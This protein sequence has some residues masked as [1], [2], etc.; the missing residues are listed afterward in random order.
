MK[1]DHHLKAFLRDT[2]NLNQT[3][4][5]T[6]KQRVETITDF[7]KQLED[8]KDLFI[9]AKPQGSWAHG[10]II[11]PVGNSEFDADIVVFLKE[12][13]DWEPKDYIDSLYRGFKNSK[14][15][16][17]MVGRN[18]RCVTLDYSGDFHLDVVPCIR[19]ENIWNE[20]TEWI[21]NRTE[22][23]EEQTNPN[24][25]SEWF[26]EK[27][28]ITDGYL[29]K[30]VRL[31]K[32]LRDHKKTFSA[33]SILLTT[34]LAE[35]VNALDGLGSGFCD[36]ST[37][38]STIFYRLDDYLQ[39]NP[40]MPTIRNPSLST[41]DFNRHWNQEKYDNFRNCIHRYR[42]WLEDAIAEPD[43]DESILKWRKIFGDDFAK[44]VV[45]ESTSKSATIDYTEDLSHVQPLQWPFQQYARIGIRASIYTDEDG[46]YLG[47]LR[48]DGPQLKHGTWIK[49]EIDRPIPRGQKIVWQV[50]NTGVAARRAG[51]LRGG[52]DKSGKVNWEHVAFTG[53]HWVECFLIHQNNVC[54]AR[55]GRFYVNVE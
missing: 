12:N 4:I 7:V 52:F 27:S 3:R 18:T 49:F 10:T 15:Y 45:V 53:T 13:D 29:I 17:N 19:R 23:K 34:I 51:Q 8:F 46:E 44:E 2:V 55:S 38:L 26:L 28:K 30:V 22:N 33:K 11:K 41:E 36:L 48:S 54:I 9:E 24:G 35:R 25:Y 31:F 32:Y 1:L 37:S 14:T 42:E 39:D 40:S 50:V 20:V 16:E 43:R 5:D 47:S 6:L 21:L